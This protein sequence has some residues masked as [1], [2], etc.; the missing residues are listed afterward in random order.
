MISYFSASIG[1]RNRMTVDKQV[2]KSEMYKK[3]DYFIFIKQKMNMKDLE[4][5]YNFP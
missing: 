4:K 2:L 3:D 1:Q 5:E